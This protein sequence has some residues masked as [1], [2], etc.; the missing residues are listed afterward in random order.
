MSGPILSNQG[1]RKISDENE[2]H[3]GQ[4]RR[5]YDLESNPVAVAD[6]RRQ[7][8]GFASSAAGA[9]EGIRSGT[10]SD[11]RNPLAEKE[12][13]CGSG[14]IGGRSIANSA[15]GIASASARAAS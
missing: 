5:A 2:W 14:K 10:S 4:R 8:P 7:Q 9:V 3:A 11:T 15:D 13:L 12:L 6:F 1:I